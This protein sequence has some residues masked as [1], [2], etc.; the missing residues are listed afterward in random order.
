MK[1]DG[2]A[3]G[4]TDNPA[5]LRHWMLSGPEMARLIGKLEV[6]TK[7][8]NKTDFRY[9]EQ[10]KHAQMTF[11]RDITLLSDVIKEMGNSFAENSKDLFVLDNRD[12]ADP[13]VVDTLR[14][15]K[16]LGQ[17]QY[18]TYVNERLV[19]Q[20]KPITDSMKRK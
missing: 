14:Q 6:S 8:R 20:T 17:E 2:G 5:A 10:R 18:D 12:L 3:V 4:L 16:S 7:K 19:N 1:G 11:G 9:H 13:A 15:I